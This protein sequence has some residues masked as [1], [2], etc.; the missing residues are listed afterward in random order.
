MVIL[1]SGIS[2]L[3]YFL[4]VLMVAIYEFIGSFYKIREN[5]IEGHGQLEGSMAP[6]I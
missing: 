5:H 3:N 6:P 4:F 1:L 2:N